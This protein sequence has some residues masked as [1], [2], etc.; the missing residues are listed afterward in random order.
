MELRHLRYFVAVAEE[1]HITRAAARLGIQQPPLSQQMQALEQELG[2]KLFTRS[3]RMIRLNAAGKI[4]LSDARRV[5][6]MANEAVNRVRQFDL[7]EEGCVRVGFTSSASIH[8]RT[9]AI[10]QSFRTECPLVSLKIEEG[11]NHDLLCLVEQERLDVA[12]V[13]SGTERYPTLASECLLDENMVAAIPAASPLAAST[14]PIGLMELADENFVVYRQVNGSGIAELMLGACKRAGF[15]PRIVQETERMM[16]AIQMVA[17]GFGL[18]IVPQSM[19]TFM[20]RL[21]VYRPLH[22]STGFTVPLKVV[23]RKHA[24]AETQKKFLRACAVARS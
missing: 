9:L 7:G 16:S 5:L 2:V 18:A 12:F 23:Y 20:N 19:Q 3:P 8:D 13:R 11:A 24:G 17:S 22:I 14:E 21:V 4:F 10:I 1:E 15:Q 6:A